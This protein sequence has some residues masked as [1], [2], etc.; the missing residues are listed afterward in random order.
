[1]PLSSEDA[2][3]DPQAERVLNKVRRLMAISVMF[4]GLAIIAVL[5][6]VGYRVYST[7]QSAATPPDVAAVLPAGAR[8]VA[9]SLGDGRL[10]VTIE[11]DGRTEVR[12]FDLDTLQPRGRLRFGAER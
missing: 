11:I 3:L 8:V 2:P 10:A 12:L 6:V 7:G 4:T 9:S 1:M 5:I